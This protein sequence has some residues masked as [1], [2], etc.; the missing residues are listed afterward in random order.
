MSKEFEW[1]QVDRYSEN[2]GSRVDKW[3]E[4][5]FDSI[6]RWLIQCPVCKALLGDLWDADRHRDWHIKVGA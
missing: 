1:P 4:Y 5:G 3:E 6:P 2:G